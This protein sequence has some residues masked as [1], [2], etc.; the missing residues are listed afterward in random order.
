MAGD[1]SNRK[2]GNKKPSNPQGKGGGKGKSV[3][4]RN[5][6]A[7]ATGGK[8]SSG[9]DQQS[10]KNSNTAAL[11]SLVKTVLARDIVEHKRLKALNNL[12]AYILTPQNAELVCS[13][14]AGLFATLEQLLDDPT[15]AVRKEAAGLLGVLGVSGGEENTARFLDWACEALLPSEEWGEAIEGSLPRAPKGMKEGLRRVLAGR[16]VEGAVC[17]ADASYMEAF[18]PAILEQGIGL[19]EREEAS[20]VSCAASLLSSLAQWHP[21]WLLNSG[22]VESSLELLVAWAVDGSISKEVQKDVLEGLARHDQIWLEVKRCHKT[23]LI[24]APT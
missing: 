16:A 2:A 4:S 11:S 12:K 14:F 15:E 23:Q 21:V 6:G 10:E 5:K 19:L 13:K 22:R 8:G 18:F 3:N 17:A 7:G 20:G 24:Q 1:S 9:G